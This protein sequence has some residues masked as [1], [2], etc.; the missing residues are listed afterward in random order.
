MRPGTTHLAQPLSSPL[1]FRTE[2]PIIRRCCCNVGVVQIH[3]ESSTPIKKPRPR[4]PQYRRARRIFAAD[5]QCW[6]RAAYRRADEL[7]RD[8]QSRIWRKKKLVPVDLK[9]IAA[10]STRKK[11]SI[12]ILSRRNWD[13]FAQLFLIDSVHESSLWTTALF[14]SWS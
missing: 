12:E 2:G 1:S 9:I 7:H 14:L 5:L 4:R 11:N 13:F 10:L 3:S 8:R 6:S